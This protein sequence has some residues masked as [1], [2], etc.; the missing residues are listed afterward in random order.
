MFDKISWSAKIY[1]KR[2]NESGFEGKFESF[3]L[4][5]NSKNCFQEGEKCLRRERGGGGSEGGC[6]GQPCPVR[7]VGLI[8]RGASLGL[9]VEPFLWSHFES[10]SIKTNHVNP[11]FLS[12]LFRLFTL[13]GMK[14]L[15]KEE[16]INLE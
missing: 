7:H 15:S 9:T 3:L 16:V 2:K 14:K 10:N 6:N 13:T 11:K 5:S 12:S 8:S 4:V 1:H